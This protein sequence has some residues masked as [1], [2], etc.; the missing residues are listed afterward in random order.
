[1]KYLSV[2]LAAVLCLALCVVPGCNKANQQ[3]AE[4]GDVKGSVAGVHWGVPKRWTPQAD[5][6]MRA[7]T[8]TVPP[9]S[10]GA[11][12]CECAVFHFPGGQGG[13]PAANISR[14]VTQFEEGAQSSQSSKEVNGLKV[15]RVEIE[16]TYTSPGGMM[17]QPTAKKENYRL[18]GAIVQAPEGFVFF[19]YTGPK[20]AVV[21]SAGEFDAMIGSLAK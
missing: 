15:T 8:Y 7:A 11:D 9:A 5:R 19:K 1:M 14:W 16:G 2:F 21:A 17:M 18:L 12:G 3:S 20:E 4:L 10:A 13:D 6:P